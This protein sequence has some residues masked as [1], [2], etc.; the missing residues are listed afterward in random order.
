MIQPATPADYR[1]LLR[2]WEASVRSTHH[3]LAEEDLQYYKSQITDHYFPHVRLH[4]IRNPQQEIVAFIGLSEELIETL[5]IHPFYQKRGYGK[6]LLE[7][8]AREYRIFRV[9]VNEQNRQALDFYQHQGFEIINRSATDS[10]GKPYPILHLQA[11][12]PK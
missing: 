10:A 2:V 3:F 12:E 6:M 1:E 4:L 5:F 7:F 11:K 9:D 8:A